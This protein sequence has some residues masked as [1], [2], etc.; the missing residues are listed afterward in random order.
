M[1]KINMEDVR[2]TG[3]VGL[4]G[5]NV[6]QNTTDDNYIPK[7]FKSDLS[8]LEVPGVLSVG[9]INEVSSST[10]DLGKSRF[11]EDIL[12]IEQ[13]QDV[14][15]MRGEN[16]HWSLKWLAGLGKMG[17]LTA[18]TFTDNFL[19]TLAG[20]VNIV[21]QGVN[22]NIDSGA[23]AMDAFVNNPVS[24]VLQEV[25]NKAEEWMPNYKTTEEMNAP[26]W[27]RMGTANFWADGFLKNTGFFLGAYLSGMTTAAGLTKAMQLDKAKLAFKGITNS[28][29]ETLKTASE[30]LKAYKTGD[31][32]MDGKILTDN[33]VA[34]AKNLKRK[35]IGV[36][37]AAGISGS[38]GES[39]IE[40]ISN[41]DESYNKL[42]KE[43]ETARERDLAGIDNE[44]LHENP[45]WFTYTLP[46]EGGI[47]TQAQLTH[48][49][50][51]ARKKQLENAINAHYDTQVETLANEKIATSN[52]TFLWNLA[53][54]S[55]DNMWQ[56]GEA[57][58]GGFKQSRK[59]AAVKRIADGTY[60]KS[61]RDVIGGVSDIF[62][63]MLFEGG[64]EMAQKSI[65]KTGERWMG[66][67]LNDYYGDAL[68][69]EA[70]EA[71]DTYFG[72]LMKTTAQTLG[73]IEEYE[74]FVLGAL[75]SLLPMPGSASVTGI[76][77]ALKAGAESQKNAEALNSV[78]NDSNKRDWIFHLSRLFNAQKEQDV[79]IE[80]NDRLTFKNAS[81]DK[82]ISSVITYTENDKFQDLLDIIE[83]SYD[84]TEEDIDT[85]K[86]LTI[87]KT[88]GKSLYDGMTNEEILE[89]FK[90]NKAQALE[91]AQ[92]IHDTYTAISILYGGKTSQEGINTLTYLA[93]RID[94]RERRI[95]Q[96]SDEI[97]KSINDNIQ[98]FQ[99]EYGYSPIEM[100]TGIKDLQAWYT[101]EDKRELGIKESS[102][103]SKEALRE[104]KKAEKTIDS[105]HKKKVLEGRILGLQN[106]VRRL[107][108][109][110]A[111]GTITEKEQKRLEKAKATIEKTKNR[112]PVIRESLKDLKAF[113]EKQTAKSKIAIQEDTQK[114]NDL[115]YLL[116]EREILTDSF[117]RLQEDPAK[118]E[119]SLSKD[120]LDS[121]D[122]YNTRVQKKVYAG[123]KRSKNKR[124]YIKKAVSEGRATLPA[125]KKI[126]EE[127]KNGR[128]IK[129]EIENIEA[130]G[131][132]ANE[133]AS[134]IKSDTTEIP[135]NEQTAPVIMQIMK[136]LND[137]IWEAQT[138]EEADKAIEEFL[139]TLEG[140][141]RP[142]VRDVAKAIKEE[143]KDLE[144]SNR[145]TSKR[146]DT[147][148][149]E[150][151]SEEL[152]KLKADKNYK[153]KIK[154]MSREDLIKFIEENNIEDEFIS[155]GEDEEDSI[156]WDEL[157]TEGIV[158]TL[159]SFIEKLPEKN[160]SKPSSKKSIHK[161][162]DDDDDTD[163]SEDEDEDESDE[164]DEEDE[165]IVPETK[166]ST[167][168]GSTKKGF[169]SKTQILNPEEV[170]NKKLKK[171]IVGDSEAGSIDENAKD[172]IKDAWHGNRGSSKYNITLLKNGT[173]QTV[174][175]ET[176][177]YTKWLNKPEIGHQEFIDSGELQRLKEYHEENGDKL[178]VRFIR[179]G[180]VEATNKKGEKY[181]RPFN[182][183][184]SDEWWASL[185]ERFWKGKLK[186]T[187]D[188]GFKNIVQGETVFLA[189]ELPK[190]YKKKAGTFT[191]MVDDGKS[192]KKVQ[193]IGVADHLSEPLRNA[194]K[195]ETEGIDAHLR[196]AN[197]STE[198]EWV[199]SGRL[200]K[201]NSDLSKGEHD[202]KDVLPKGSAEGLIQLEI[203]T[204]TDNVKIGDDLK[205]TVV[206]LN[207]NR[208]NITISNKT[209]R[210]GT[211]WMKTRE[212]DGRVYYKSVKIK[213]F[214]ESYDDTKSAYYK[215]IRGV[216]R[217]IIAAETKESSKNALAALR[218][219]LYLGAGKSPLYKDVDTDTLIFNDN[220]ETIDLSKL[221]EETI[222]QVI[223]ALKSRGYRF[224]LGLNKLSLDEIIQS[225]ILTTDLA[226]IHNAGASFVI[227]KVEFDEGGDWYITPSQ[228]VETKIKK[229]I[230]TGKKGLQPARGY[231]N[232]V[233]TEK[234]EIYSQR[235]DGLW[236][237]Y[238][239]GEY[240]VIDDE[241]TESMKFRLQFLV[242]MSYGKLGKAP[243]YYHDANRKKI[244]VWKRENPHKA[245][246]E[247]YL[248]EKGH[249]LTAEEI[250]ALHTIQKKDE[251]ESKKKKANA[252]LEQIHTKK[253]GRKTKAAEEAEE[254]KDETEDEA[255]EEVAEPKTPAAEVKP[256][257]Q[258][259]PA[260]QY[261][262]KIGEDGTDFTGTG[263]PVLDAVI[264]RSS[265]NDTILEYVDENFEDSTDFD[266]KLIDLYKKGKVSEEILE[267]V[268][269]YLNEGEFDS[270]VKLL[271]DIINCRV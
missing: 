224:S 229:G 103:K 56:F 169:S 113:I 24:R 258:P 221:D 240:K 95:T 127:D 6:Q 121:I 188:L 99:D 51:L 93:S 26:W 132:K 238:E 65:S 41:T 222:N 78:K 75:T 131:K 216:V 94:D 47:P 122:S 166:R 161:D 145:G 146:E 96:I 88:T 129:L 77:R 209:D 135:I 48:P 123:V 252:K 163:E 271:D 18:T 120:I 116:H 130:L 179:I 208:D 64:Q 16:Q 266:N 63:S 193:L 79:A 59:L 150:P 106:V 46:K 156:T 223:D 125:L 80:E 234:G 53:V 185:K 31:A 45:N 71:M 11:D 55:L 54:T 100:L 89:H 174:D 2:K 82:A 195:A 136:D 38:M 111:D 198:L 91:N 52:K 44:L 181:P 98:A 151:I 115:L 261:A 255:E 140:V 25:N 173:L 186:D 30:V 199:Y 269:D 10:G 167:A 32:V 19:G 232:R 4:K 28:K 230:H 189:V 134:I 162:N 3:P 60:A 165:E 105:K 147:K 203:I 40:A 210:F 241:L 101:D 17:V 124:N 137:I 57:F 118:L 211:L 83:D 74:D 37:I 237:I 257:P 76:S 251:K 225:N 164:E 119:E 236:T 20:L 242:D 90:S 159:I 262:N 172:D 191:T 139:T 43:L 1:V 70:L 62:A 202:L 141:R 138:P 245:N 102:K 249:F 235:D 112:I 142:I 248:D 171:Q 254:E 69:P 107:E 66:S 176:E 58:T 219:Y 200:V 160:P 197:V 175:P 205:G 86:A 152:Y 114:V 187:N 126:A 73:D 244:K 117:N 133:I 220:G 239:N 61:K 35:E 33:L 247:E 128:E 215:G 218:R 264:K 180:S 157:D 153:D 50:G 110:V 7:R 184:Q 250:K 259:K 204:Q 144:K 265:L 67:K 194:I 85:L 263:V 192:T 15:T 109:K 154:A 21:H 72:T 104:A 12:S 97:I 217:D 268:I 42:Y 49:E 29:G 178:R 68:N 256:K 155:E 182:D 212:A 214:D 14:N 22:G 177:W 13:L 207:T 190:G 196:M 92:R 158:D 9:N 81:M 231:V 148:E 243:N 34:A 170:K 23:E 226:Q 206:P 260:S 39:R 233:R 108:A 27:Q 201:E 168:K 36:K 5:V 213:N 246:V 143:L 227:S 270:A 183:T 267:K 84:V 87:D 8:Y 228:D 149:E 253:N